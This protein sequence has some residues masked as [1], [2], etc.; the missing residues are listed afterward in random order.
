MGFRNM[1]RFSDLIITHSQ[2]GV[3]YI[4]KNWPRYRN[5][6]HYFIHPVIGAGN[7]KPKCEKEY[8]I[9][10]W[11]TVYPY[12]GIADFSRYAKNSR[13]LSTL[14]ILIIG[15]CFDETYRTELQSCLSENITYR[16][17]F[18]EMDGI[19]ELAQ[20]SRFILFTYNSP[21]VLSSGSLM[22]TVTMG[23]PIIGPDR[24]AF[25]DLS[26][27]GFIN[28]YHEFDEIEKIIKEYK[29]DEDRLAEVIEKF[30]HE[31]SWEK[32]SD[33][34]EEIINSQLFQK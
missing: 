24:G 20:K 29:D 8:D 26:R 12:K 21:S 14:K 18:I 13:F 4:E 32:F 34:I 6:V 31:N 19:E 11:G 10:I 16:D 9:L 27:L 3:E 1:I 22:D 7:V 23:R 2:G 5:K 28:T 25:R 15:K 30:C 33:R 17:E